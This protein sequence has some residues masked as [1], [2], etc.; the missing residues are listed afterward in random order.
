MRAV[1]ISILIVLSFLYCVPEKD[2]KI[3]HIPTVDDIFNEMI[4][5]V[6]SSEEHVYAYTDKVGGFWE[7]ITYAYN[8]SGGGYNFEGYRSLLDFV[9]SRNDSILNRENATSVSIFPHQIVHKWKGGYAEK[10]TVLPEENGMI[11]TM[12]GES[13]VAWQFMPMIAFDPAKIDVETVEDS[14]ILV[15][16]ERGSRQLIA[17]HASAECIWKKFENELNPVSPHINRDQ[18]VGLVGSTPSVKQVSYIILFGKDK[19][20]LSHRITAIAKNPESL[21]DMK[22]T[23]IGAMLRDSYSRTNIPEYDKALNW[24]KVSGDALVVTQFGTGIWAGLPWFN[25]SWGRDTFIALPGIS[26]VTGQ[27]EDARNVIESFS[28]YQMEDE[29][30]RLY[31]RVPNRVVSPEDVIYNTTDGTPWLIR[32][33]GEYLFYT[34]DFDFAEK[35]YPVIKRAID[36][37]LKNFVDKDGL[38]TH[39]DA[40]TWMDARIGGQQAWS[41]RGNRAVDIQSLWYNQLRLSAMIADSLGYTDDASKWNALAEKLKA[42]FNKLFIDS[43]NHALFDHLNSDGSPDDQIRPNQLFAITIPQFD[44]LIECETGAGVVR[45]VVSELTFPY[46]IASLS[47]NDPY[48]HPYHH[49]QIYHFDAAYHNGLC[50]HWNVGPLVS[51]MTKF[52]YHDKAFEITMN[53]ADQILNTGMPGSL[54]ELV[55]PK[56]NDDGS[57]KPT[58]TYSQAWSVSE[59][60]RNFYQDYMGLHVNMLNR[61][62]TVNPRLPEQL[63]QVEC[64]LNVGDEERIQCMFNSKGERA[65]YRFAGSRL[66]DEVNI[67]LRLLDKDYAVYEISFMLKHGKI[68]ELSLVDWDTMRMEVNGKIKELKKTDKIIPNP[69][70]D[71]EFQKFQLNSNLKSL[72]VPNFLEKLRLNENQNW[73]PVE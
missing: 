67:K 34:G 69:D 29:E 25:Q 41:P 5:D 7:G 57:V 21:V 26:L 15:V 1:V 65:T 9:I 72:Q 47:Q 71:L 10:I 3:M 24:A 61:I 40:D 45:Q 18:I 43:N 53:L 58:G 22:K 37:S 17:I 2:A 50:W 30:S 66:I 23:M 31:G 4:I 49:D 73:R 6:K 11:V 32:E 19:S 56:L 52:G 27:F 28:D 62:L 54:S 13:N 36:G 68:I 70:K 12:T 33:I 46:G 35:M 63:H 64:V 8:T 55:E 44:D 48:F 39:D 16:H 38:L 51:A 60:V 59:F 20:K 42:N 14:S